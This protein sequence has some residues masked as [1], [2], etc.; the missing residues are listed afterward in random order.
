MQ[1]LINDIFD[2]SWEI[3]FYHELT[4]LL[5]NT[6]MVVEIFNAKKSSLHFLLGNTFFAKVKQ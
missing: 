5:Q 1:S 2:R 4:F 3:R 6:S